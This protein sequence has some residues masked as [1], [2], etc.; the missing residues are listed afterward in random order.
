M[1]KHM[2][3]ALMCLNGNCTPTT[4]MVRWIARPFKYMGILI[5]LCAMIACSPW[6]SRT[7][8]VLSTLPCDETNFFYPIE[9]NKDGTALHPDKMA[10]LRSKIADNKVRDIFVFVHGWDH[11]IEAATDHYKRTICLFHKKALA[12]GAINHNAAV[13]IGVFW[14]STMWEGMSDP[15][16][17]KPATYFAIRKRADIMAETAFPNIMNLIIDSHKTSITRPLKLRFIGHSFGGRIVIHGLLNYIQ[18]HP[19]QSHELIAGLQ[20]LQIVL[21]NAAASSN[22]LEI[23]TSEKENAL[24]A[25]AK[26]TTN[27]RHPIDSWFTY[28]PTLRE[29]V[30]WFHNVHVYNVFS[31]KDWATRYL[32]RVGTLVTSDTDG[33]A[34]GGCPANDV[35]RATWQ[36][37]M[38]IIVLDK[39]GKI[40]ETSK[41]DLT[42][43]ILNIDASSVINSHTDIY[44]DAVAELLADL[45][46]VTND[47]TPPKHAREFAETI[48]D[49][50]L[51]L[52]KK[53]WSSALLHIRRAY[54]L[55]KFAP[56]WYVSLFV[57]FALDEPWP[58]SGRPKYSSRVSLSYNYQITLRVLIMLLLMMK[59]EWQ[60]ADDELEYI[61]D[62]D[63]R[64]LP[65]RRSELDYILSHYDRE[66]KLARRSYD[67]ISKD[68]YQYLRDQY[69]V[70]TKALQSMN[71]LF[72]D[73]KL[74]PVDLFFAKVS[75]AISFH[76]LR[77]R[78]ESSMHDGSLISSEFW[79]HLRNG[80][81]EQLDNSLQQTIAAE[82]VAAHD[83]P[84]SREKHLLLASHY[85]MNRGNLAYL[86][87]QSKKAPAHFEQA[88]SLVPEQYSFV[89]GADVLIEWARALLVSKRYDEAE[90]K[91]LT[92]LAI[93][94]KVLGSEAVEVNS[95]Q[96]TLASIYEGQGNYTKAADLYCRTITS[97]HKKPFDR[98]VGGLLIN[99]LIAYESVLNTTGQIE[100]KERINHFRWVIRDQYEREFGN[101]PNYTYS[102]TTNS[103]R[104][105]TF[106]GEGFCLTGRSSVMD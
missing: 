103:L 101:Q 77:E 34:L 82:L 7:V 32:Y 85:A 33:C 21:L 25:E 67:G 95:V 6:Q 43:R 106:L 15:E 91:L 88:H 39:N 47:A 20:S 26:Q 38:P 58:L 55:S 19:L 100:L 63:D 9:F 8:E 45:S 57:R 70:T 56:G 81:F 105:E 54:H 2:F 51:Y 29:L 1:G 94:Q 102:S 92:A 53:D 30:D 10:D 83:E 59:G 71:R 73:T 75:L 24:E 5:V 93:K 40:E 72:T 68:D 89:S 104:D 36:G 87:G 60:E 44:K 61:W 12:E 37:R 49:A 86:L 80:R 27:N 31:S 18:M 22:H 78:F 4:S 35:G 69:G 76:S 98:N 41:S 66:G 90:K 13:M 74:D 84:L 50:N 42:K 79:D 96:L 17:L 16:I 99:G 3:Q 52:E 23:D 48:R 64:Y 46:K 11:T 97:L 14:K 65:L 28:E 62:A